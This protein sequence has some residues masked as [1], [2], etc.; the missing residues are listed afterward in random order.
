MI[1]GWG[2]G[3]S[4]S[5]SRWPAAS[6]GHPASAARPGTRSP[7]DSSCCAS[8]APG[9]RPTAQVRSGQAAAHA[10]GRSA[11]AWTSPAASSPNV[12]VGPS[13]SIPG[14]ATRYSGS[15]SRSVRMNDD[16]PLQR[17]P[18]MANSEITKPWSGRFRYYAQ[19]VG[20]GPRTLWE[21][22]CGAGSILR[23]RLVPGHVGSASV[24]TRSICHDRRERLARLLPGHL[25]LHIL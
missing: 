7:A 11:S 4:C 9:R 1:S 21:N 16:A 3:R 10:S 19:S 17:F 22:P 2:S 18:G 13:K 15:R 24:L 6:P 5:R 14:R 8:D 12:T 23:F 25:W 20:L